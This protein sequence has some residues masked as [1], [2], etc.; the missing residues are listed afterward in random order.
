MP[1]EFQEV[2]FGTEQNATFSLTGNQLIFS[3]TYFV[4]L[5]AA[6]TFGELSKRQL[7]RT[8]I[9]AK[10]AITKAYFAVLVSEKNEKILK[11]SLEKLN[12]ILNDTR[13]MY[14][15]G[16]VEELDV[17]RLE[18]TVS[19]LTNNLQVVTS[20]SELAYNLLKFQ[21]G[22]N[23]KDSIKLTDKL[24]SFISAS[25]NSEIVLADFDYTERIE[26]KILSSQLELTKR[27]LKYYQIQY[28]PTL[29]AFFTHQENAQRN[30]FNF[31]D[32]D[33]SWYPITVW[34]LNVSIPIFDG[35]YKSAK[36]QQS[37]LEL[38]KVNNA[39]LQLEQSLYLEMKNAETNYNNAY[40]KYETQQ[41]NL[42]L[43]QKI[44]DKTLI[45]YNEGIATSVELS[46][47]ENDM[48]Q[49]QSQYINALYELLL[50]KAD[51]DKALAN[52]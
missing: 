11:E 36:V 46:S 51:L 4:G 14:K 18:L 2:Q 35:F 39:R 20:Q 38:E 25:E 22:F 9:D 43:A 1:G 26:F 41:K 40:A 16:F 31:F 3:G 37:R 17:N 13:E 10:D 42:E 8:I 28:I 5:Q 50:A 34:G 15:N 33:E 32:A 44:H 6:R 30:Q 47:A 12:K 52:Y 24:T 19:N 7:E 49:T 21:M 27:N 48:L 45:K 23:I 29:S